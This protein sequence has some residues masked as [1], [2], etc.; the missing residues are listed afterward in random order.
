MYKI[1]VFKFANNGLSICAAVYFNSDPDRGLE[2]AKMVH[3]TE[4]HYYRVGR[5]DED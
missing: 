5:A 3:G 4:G 2:Q 1:K